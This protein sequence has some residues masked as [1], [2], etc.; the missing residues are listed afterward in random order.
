[1]TLTSHKY[2]GFGDYS[3]GEGVPD[4][5]QGRRS[6][7]S[8]PMSLTIRTALLHLTE[9]Y[10]VAVLAVPWGISSQH[11][12][13]WGVSHSPSKQ[14]PSDH[15]KLQGEAL[16]E[17][18]SIRLFWWM[19]TMTSRGRWRLSELCTWGERPS[20]EP[21]TL[22]PNPLCLHLAALH[23]LSELPHWPLGHIILNGMSL[24]Y[25]LWDLRQWGLVLVRWLRLPSNHQPCQGLSF[26]QEAR[27]PQHL[28]W[29]DF[30]EG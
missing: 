14:P 21:Q 1:M 12:S 11:L 16:R 30:W 6:T 23:P 5:L 20:T 4:L 13:L 19:R 9:M 22:T 2:L 29:A 7:E 28:V 26:N 3:I 24:I 10:H 8:S 27:F 17:G 25:S 15:L 18:G